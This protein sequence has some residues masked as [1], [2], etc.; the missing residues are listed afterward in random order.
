MLIDVLSKVFD[1]LK[2]NN[3]ITDVLKE[4]NYQ[5]SINVTLTRFE[6]F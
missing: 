5:D 2:Q 3:N 6:S 1:K 4:V